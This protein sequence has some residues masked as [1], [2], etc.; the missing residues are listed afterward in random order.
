MQFIRLEKYLSSIPAVWW[1]GDFQP[2]REV[3]RRFHFVVLLSVISKPIFQRVTRMFLVS[4]DPYRASRV[5]WPVP[6]PSRTQILKELGSFYHNLYRNTRP[7]RIFISDNYS[8][9]DGTT[10]IYFP[11]IT[12]NR[13]KNRPN[14]PKKTNHSEPTGIIDHFPEC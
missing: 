10:R 4:G 11:V 13:P 7:N 2:R 9:L 3:Y 6:Q 1:P 14:G 12:E 5:L 8:H